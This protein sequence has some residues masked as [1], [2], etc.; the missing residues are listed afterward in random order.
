[1]ADRLTRSEVIV[2]R[3]VGEE[4]SNKAIARRLGV[5]LNTV[6]NHLTNAYRK[7]GTSERRAAALLVARDYPII[8]QLPP[9]AMASA[10]GRTSD[11]PALG[12][13]ARGNDD[14]GVSRWSLP[15]PPSRPLRLLGLILGFAALSGLVTGGLVL[16]AQG[17]IQALSASAPPT[18]VLALEP[19]PSS[20]TP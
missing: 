12:D 2:L 5:S 3:L 11:D 9:I 20:R 16:V 18:A 13:E 17:G 8:S 14:T 15:A 19:T 10:S 6:Q 1:M 7:L 4:L